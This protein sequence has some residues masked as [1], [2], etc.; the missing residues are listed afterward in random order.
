MEA[1]KI[2]VPFNV[3]I[4]SSLPSK[5]IK[6]YMVAIGLENSGGGIKEFSNS[7]TLSFKMELSLSIYPIEMF[8]ASHVAS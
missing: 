6:G 8:R 5:L 3:D 4:D 7:L 2:D 1:N